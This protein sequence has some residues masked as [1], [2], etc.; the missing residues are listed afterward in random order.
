MSGCPYITINQSCVRPAS[1]GVVII[2]GGN[3]A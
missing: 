1:V 3:R 2:I